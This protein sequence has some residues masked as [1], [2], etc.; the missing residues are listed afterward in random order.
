MIY[1]SQN[2]SYFQVVNYYIWQ[3]QF[4]LFQ[5]YESLSNCSGCCPLTFNGAYG[6]SES[7]H[8]IRLCSNKKQRSVYLYAHFKTKHHLTA[9]NARRLVEAIAKNQK[10]RKT[11][12]FNDNEDIID[13]SR[14]IECPFRKGINHLFDS[15]KKTSIIRVPCHYQSAPGRGLKQ[16][17]KRYHRLS[18]DLATKFT[19]Y[20]STQIND[21]SPS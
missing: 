3:K 16:H 2:D 1:F 8:S 4:F 18:E 17:L 14:K 13:P 10:P 15:H 19:Q 9:A 20:Y 7:K 21:L 5:N 11:K 6:L 12:L